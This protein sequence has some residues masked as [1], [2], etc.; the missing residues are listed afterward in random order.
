M[1]IALNATNSTY[2]AGITQH[3]ERNSRCS[4]PRFLFLILL[5]DKLKENTNKEGNNAS[6]KEVKTWRGDCVHRW[7]RFVC[8]L[9]K[10]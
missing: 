5:R 7:Y 8:W 1:C 6:G 3:T 2:P 4:R 10:V 9:T